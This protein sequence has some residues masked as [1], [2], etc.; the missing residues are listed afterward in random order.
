MRK[1]PVLLG[2]KVNMDNAIL[3]L[4]A[5]EQGLDYTPTIDLDLQDYPRVADRMLQNLDGLTMYG[6]FYLVMIP[7]CIFMVLFELLMR[8]K[9][10][11][12]RLGM[13]L[14]GT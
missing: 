8:E 12:L 6:A 7:L 9:I 3:E 13:Q 5:R 4:R 11:N 2:L 14:L 1:D 10:D